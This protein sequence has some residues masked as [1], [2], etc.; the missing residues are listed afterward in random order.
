MS[1]SESLSASWKKREAYTDGLHGTKF[2]N[3]WRAVVF[4]IK[5]KQVGCEERWKKFKN[6]KD[7]M[8]DSYSQGLKLSRKDKTK[9]FSMDNC[10]WISPDAA[11][12]HRLVKFTYEGVEKPLKQWCLEF[13][14]SYNGARQRYHKGKNYTAHEILFGK[15]RRKSRKISEAGELTPQGV[16]S[17]ASKMISQY[18]LNDKKKGMAFDERL[19]I[20][21][22][23]DNIRGKECTY[24]GTDKKIGADRVFNNIGH[25]IENIVP[26]C[27]RCNVVRHDHFTTE[28]M[29]ILGRFIREEIDNKRI[30]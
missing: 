10:E 2:H 8:Y 4:T 29:V 5:G 7:D 21:W 6:F 28:E 27:Y 17:K 20:E 16:R 3:C 25:T 11:S 26:C 12:E 15:E 22:F 13:D 19:N 24:C 9:H 18:K 14:I 30:K 23:I 1:R